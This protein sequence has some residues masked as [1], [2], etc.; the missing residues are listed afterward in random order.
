M[1]ALLAYI[2]NM[3]SRCR[4][5]C[6]LAKQVAMPWPKQLLAAVDDAVR[7]VDL[8]EWLVHSCTHHIVQY[9]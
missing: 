3:H 6:A 5:L 7:N 9:Y 4:A 8:P 2:T 1:L